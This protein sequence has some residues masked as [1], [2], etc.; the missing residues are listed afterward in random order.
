MLLR[1]NNWMSVHLLNCLCTAQ[2]CQI[3]I[4]K[5]QIKLNVK[6]TRFITLKTTKIIKR[7]CVCNLSSIKTN[8]SQPGHSI[9]YKMLLVP[10]AFAQSDRILCWLPDDNWDPW[11]ATVPCEV[12]SKTARMSRII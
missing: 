8:I 2:V 4:R 6:R 9:S 10:G 5:E 3:L 12:S 11:L 7:V 1:V